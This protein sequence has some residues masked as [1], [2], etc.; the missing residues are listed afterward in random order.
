MLN[1]EM[2]KGLPKVELHCHLDGSIQIATLEK[3]AL[4]ENLP[5]KKLEKAIAPKKC[6]H[7]KEYLESFDI[8]LPLLQSEENLKIAAYDLIEQVGRENVCYIEI[9]FAPLLH[10]QKNLSI[11]QIIGAVLDGIY[12]AQKVFNVHVNLLISAMRHH[13]EQENFKLIKS[14]KKMK[15]EMIVGF[16][17]AGDEQQVPN[18]KI[19]NA[20]ALA[21]NSDLKLTLHSG[22]CGCA[23]NVIEAI[24]IGAERIG[25]GVAIKDSVEAMKY[26]V[27]ENILLELCPTSNIQTNAINNWRDYPFRLFLENDVKCCINTDNRTVSQTTLTN[28]YLLLVKHCQLTFSEMKQ[29]NLNA[30]NGSFANTTVKNQLIKKIDS[31]YSQISTVSKG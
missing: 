20:A 30:I 21:I 9:R 26:C 27:E 11:E 8:V 12:E 15:S 25:H 7:L 13:T 23:Q 18:D 29:L 2:I 6:L 3:L 19:R 24:H 14:I 28:E 4:K 1:E 10:Q 5:L 31:D 16:D 17:F 22:E